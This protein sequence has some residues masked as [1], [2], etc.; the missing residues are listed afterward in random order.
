MLRIEKILDV[1]SQLV[2]A[3]RNRR[4]LQFS[5]PHLDC[6][7]RISYSGMEVD[8]RLTVD[9]SLKLL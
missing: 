7:L 4:K 5:R 8:P 6:M 2:K 3:Y 1:V 9:P